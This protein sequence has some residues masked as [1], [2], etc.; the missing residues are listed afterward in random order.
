MLGVVRENEET[1][2]WEELGME[3]EFNVEEKN[4]LFGVYKELESELER[5]SKQFI[6]I[7]NLIKTIQDMNL[8]CKEEIVI[9]LSFMLNL[10]H[11][12]RKLKE[13]LNI[14]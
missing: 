10:H 6:D 8:L 1:L 5:R 14:Q 4:E 11:I 3:Y 2:V 9:F 7:T 13:I 12:L